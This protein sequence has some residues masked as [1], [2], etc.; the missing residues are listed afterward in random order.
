MKHARDLKPKDIEGTN[1]ASLLRSE[2]YNRK[3]SFNISPQM[4]RVIDHVAEKAG[5]SPSNV[6]R[7]ALAY[8]L[9]LML[10]ELQRE[11][12]PNNHIDQSR[13]AHL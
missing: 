13:V 7:N 4:E 1:L 11:A 9:P 8:A 3:K 5:I 12:S 6:I 10:A 2:S